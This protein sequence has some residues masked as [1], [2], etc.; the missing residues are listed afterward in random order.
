MLRPALFGILSLTS[1]T[2]VAAQTLAP[3]EIIQVDTYSPSGRPGSSTV[4]YIK[5]TINDPN[6]A[7]NAT[8]NCNI[9]WD[10]LT[11]GETPYNTA[12]ECTP[13]EDGTWEFEVLR[14]DPDSERPSISNS[15][16]ASRA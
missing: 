12:L 10:G 7:S 9:E 15:S 4:S 2:I 3:W 5:T 13:V 6:S 16:F 8:A 14:A 1:S 11:N